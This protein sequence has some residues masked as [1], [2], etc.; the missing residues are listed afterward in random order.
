MALDR[1]RDGS[2]SR[3][4]GQIGLKLVL[5]GVLATAVIVTAA[6]TQQLLAFVLGGFKGGWAKMRGPLAT[7]IA[8]QAVSKSK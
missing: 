8:A 2:P 7:M 4:D 3:D 1:R 6:G 5:F